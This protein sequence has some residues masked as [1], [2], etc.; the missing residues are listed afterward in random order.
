MMS[1]RIAIALALWVGVASCAVTGAVAAATPPDQAAPVPATDQR[2]T[3]SYAVEIKAET[4]GPNRQDG[5]LNS[6]IGVLKVTFNPDGSITGTYKPDDGNFTFIR[7]QRTGPQD[8]WVLIRGHRFT[9]GFTGTGLAL[10]SPP[11]ASGVTLHLKGTF[12]PA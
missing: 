10:T 5:D 12:Q 7:G 4:I 8:L 1:T 2:V 3:Y 11:S 6:G 9:G